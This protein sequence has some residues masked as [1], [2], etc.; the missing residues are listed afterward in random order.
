MEVFVI[1]PCLNEQE[2]LAATCASLGFGPA[3]LPAGR[4]VLVDNGS[5]DGTVSVMEQVRDAC[6]P[7]QVVLVKEPKRGYVPARR[8]GAATVIACAQAERIS[9]ERV[10]LLQA[11]ADTIYLPGYVFAMLGALSG[12]PGKML[13]GCALTSRDFNAR[14][15]EF[16]QLCRIVDQG[17]ERWFAPAADQVIID[18]KISGLTLA[19][20]SA[21]GEHQE[22]VDS[23]GGQIH[24]ETTRLF[25]RAKRHGAAFRTAVESAQALPSRRK[26]ISQ[27]PAY[28][29]SSG[30]P[31]SNDWIKQWAECAD[32]TS[33]LTAPMTSSSLHRLVR[34]RQRHQIALFGLL[35]SLFQDPR[36]VVDDLRECAHLFCQQ[37]T[38]NNSGSMIELALRWADEEGGALDQVLAEAPFEA[39][40]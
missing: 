39:P 10:L 37:L 2:G 33:F 8:A 9:W 21:W 24:A 38:G 18:D 13:E 14:Y 29:A 7:G 17:M 28:F 26:I 16:T 23:C 20:Y 35:P 36:D 34:C 27:A 40:H 6:P 25:L 12:V 32:T 22:E 19:D 5:T 15:P 31:R 30:F 4:L 11:D 3:S 1:I